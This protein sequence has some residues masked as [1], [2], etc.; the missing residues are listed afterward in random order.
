MH[1]P[2]ASERSLYSQA[3]NTAQRVCIS[4]PLATSLL[5]LVAPPS[6]PGVAPMC[7]GSRGVGELLS[8][9]GAVSAAQ[10]RVETLSCACCQ[11]QHL[12]S[13]LDGVTL[14]DNCLLQLLLEERQQWR[15]GYQQGDAS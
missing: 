4:S 8:P 9:A 13:V 3:D 2:K 5:W 6:W 11:T 12:C 14:G 1:L 10:R 7:C 15:Q